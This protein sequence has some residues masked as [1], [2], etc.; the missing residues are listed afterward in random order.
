MEKDRALA[1]LMVKHPVRLAHELG[2]DLLR[3]GLHDRWIH[4]MVFGHDDMTLQ[5][6]R[7]SYKTTCVEVALWVIL[8]TRPDL[9]IGFQ[10][11]GE[12]D[13][14]EVLAA[15]SRMVEHPLTQEIA[16]SIYSQP[17]KLTTASSTAISTSLACNVSGSPQLTGI[18]IGGSLTG[19]HWDII[20]TDDIVTLRDRVSRAERERTKQVYRELQNVKNRGGRIVNTGTPWHKDDAFKLMPEPVRWPWDKTGL[21]TQKEAET[22][23]K[24]MTHSLFAANYELRH[25]AEEGAVFEGECQSFTDK[26]LLYD[27]LMHV[28]AAYGGSDGTAITCIQWRDGEPYV[29]GELY[30]ETHVD[31]CMARILELHRELR[32]GTVYMEKNADKGYVAD[33]LEGYKLPVSTYQ[34]TENKFIKISTFARGQWS[35]L[36]RLQSSVKASREYWDEVI[37]FTEGAKHDD[38]PD[39]L[40]CAIRLRENAPIIHLFKGGI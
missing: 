36:R 28:D 34:E 32:L 30:R 21:V 37:D 39:S 12:N 16:Q 38:A 11:K 17:L 8:L 5:S 4:E 1:T 27:G 29:H 10:R 9:T 40:A 35:H 3:E 14:A 22:L 31:K 33:K 25:V 19:K 7:G 18:G 20:F 13:V 6:H 2:Y 26:E 23:K 24:K 15:V